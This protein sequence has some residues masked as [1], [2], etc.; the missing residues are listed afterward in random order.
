MSEELCLKV[1]VS[2]VLI[3]VAFQGR[4]RRPVPNRLHSLLA[5][6]YLSFFRDALRVRN[7]L[8]HRAETAHFSG[9]ESVACRASHRTCACLI[10][11]PPALLALVQC[12]ASHRLFVRRV[13]VRRARALGAG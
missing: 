7:G 5:G 6:R 13:C 1:K 11:V 4:V 2:V 3:D 8:L 9:R 10:F 12:E